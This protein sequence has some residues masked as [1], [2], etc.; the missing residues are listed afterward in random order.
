MAI[1]SCA[2]KKLEHVNP[3]GLMSHKSFSQVVKVEAGKLVFISG[4]V[5]FDEE[6]KVKGLDF[7]S[8]LKQSLNN[9]SE[10]LSATGSDWDDVIQMRIYVVD[11]K[12]EH[13]FMIGMAL[14]E[15]YENAAPPASTL[16]GVQG[17][18]RKDLR[19]EIDVIAVAD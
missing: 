1:V 13:R 3:K 4:Q 17:L 7:D 8:Q 15:L 5:A 11:L 18:A 6:G 14:D 19:V 16:L 9:V 2:E 10:A 12:P